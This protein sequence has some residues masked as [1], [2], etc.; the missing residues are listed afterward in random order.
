MVRLGLVATELD[1]ETVEVAVANRS[2][3]ELINDSRLLEE[4]S[5]EL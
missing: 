1:T 2:R 5:L 4:N 3:L